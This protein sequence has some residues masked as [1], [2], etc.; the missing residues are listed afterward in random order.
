MQL[1]IHGGTPIYRERVYTYEIYHQLRSRWPGVTE[2]T[3]NGEVDKRGHQFLAQLEAANAIPDLLVHIPGNM[4]GN[5][6]IIEVKPLKSDLAGVQK[7]LE[8][9]KLFR[10]NVGYQRA[11]YLFYGGIPERHLRAAIE[12][13]PELP[14]IEL[15]LHENAGEPARM[16]RVIQS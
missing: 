10:N 16:V 6:A 9:L 15:W 4:D 7:D 13:V 3:L 2:F 11:I 14:S 12:S 1:P 8:T 5:H